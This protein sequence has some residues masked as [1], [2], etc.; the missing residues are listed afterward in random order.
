MR[1]DCRLLLLVLLATAPG[2]L[3]AA[4][5]TDTTAAGAAAPVMSATD[6]RQMI[7]TLNDPA[8][9]AA[10]VK[11][12][13]NLEKV[14]LPGVPTAQKPAVALS[15]DSLGAQL[16]AHG[17]QFADTIW[18]S[19]LVGVR[20]AGDIPA[21]WRWLQDVAQN[22]ATLLDGAI[23]V[24]SL[25]G[26]VLLAFAGQ[27]LARRMTR[28]F[29]LSLAADAS[30]QDSAAQAGTVANDGAVTTAATPPSLLMSLQDGWLL[31]LRLPIILMAFTVDLLP[32]LVFLAIATLV[33][34]TPLVAS[35]GVRTALLAVVDAFVMV[36][37][38]IAVARATFGA[39]SARLRLLPVSDDTAHYLMIWVRRIAAVIVVGYAV[40]EF[41]ALFGMDSE[42]REALLRLVSL[43]VHVMLIVMVLQS[44]ASVAARLSGTGQGFWGTLRRR[45]ASVWHIY[46]IAFIAAGWVIYAYEI[47]NGLAELLHFMLWTIV[48]ALAARI[49]DIVLVGALDRGFSAAHDHAAQYG[50]IEKRVSHYRQ[51]VRVLLRLSISV[52]ATITLLQLWG[53]DVFGWFRQGELGGRIADSSVTLLVTLGVAVALWEAVNIAM[54]VY[55][56]RLAREGVAVRAARLQTIVPLL[57]NS[58]LIV[59]MVLI[60]LTAMSELGVNIGPLLAGASIFGVAIGFGSQKLVQDFITG[61]FLLL[62]NA[63]QVGDFVTAG[64]LSGTVENL[65]IRTLRLRAGDGSVHVIPFSSV[66][67]VTNANRGLGNASVAVTVDYLEDSERVAAVLTGIAKEMREDTVFATGM[68]SD[69]QLWGVDRVDGSTMTLAGQIV[70]TD[71]ARWG[72]QREFN[73]R[74]K[75]AFQAAGIR[76]M[77]ATTAVQRPLEIKMEQMAVAKQHGKAPPVARAETAP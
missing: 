48:V 54:Q 21:L 75:I 20:G 51:P 65:S 43:L 36:R 64:G 68:L 26:V 3:A 1:P 30:R 32:P 56:D 15:P 50:H 34:G 39:P 6:A 12:L 9:R 69:L 58:L 25:L 19:L 38:V 57:R 41:G 67:T 76:M 5:A 10:L 35:S 27:W 14:A 7:D 28:R 33:S 72:V 23:A 37:I 60:A 66:S 2:A 74:V 11:T 46:A 22:P 63:M 29:Y 45:I 59:L 8:R 17:A 53:I 49:A 24:G 44:R 40:T 42:T 31:L 13:E 73:R 70:C 52:L 77:P 4:P 62:E 18:A 55:L 47:R 71:S 61:I 16:L